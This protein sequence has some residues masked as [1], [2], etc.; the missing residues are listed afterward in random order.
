MA[1]KASNRFIAIGVGQG[2]AFFLSQ[3]DRAILVD[4]GRSKSFAWQFYRVAELEEVD[5]LVCTH[6]DSDHANGVLGFLRDGLTAHEVWL[7]GSWTARLDDLLLR[8]TAF[9]QELA[10][11][12]IEAEVGEAEDVPLERR[13]DR[14]AEGRR[15]DQRVEDSVSVDSLRDALEAA[16]RY[17]APYDI[18]W[19]LVPAWPFLEWR[20][21]PDLW[22]KHELLRADQS[23]VKLLIE[24]VDAASRIREISL[25]AYNRGCAIRW[26]EYDAHRVSGGLEGILR[27][28]NSRELLKIPRPRVSALDFLALTVSN[29][30]SL[31]FVSPGTPTRPAVLFTADSD[32]SFG[33]SMPWTEG[34][35]IT[36]PHHGSESNARAYRHFN[37]Q[38]G[39]NNEMI[40]VRS[41]CL[42]RSRPGPS[43]LGVRGRRFCTICKGDSRPKQNVRLVRPGS[44]WRPLRTR[45]CSCK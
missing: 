21:Y 39:G 7:P 26:F 23:K 30:E 36:A 25:H 17:E 24:A 2:D 1:A 19:S 9:A 15:A 43:Y 20:Y 5:I 8:P 34:M 29:L 10:T 13:G 14:L 44:S 33:G 41:D 16:S 3:N 6:N 37:S 40:W 28:V 38:T 42:S 35:I 31:V 11:N 4:G 32:L 45:S 27:P 22:H 12:V 18:F